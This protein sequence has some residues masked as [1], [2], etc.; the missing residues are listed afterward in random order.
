M[1]KQTILIFVLFIVILL[2]VAFAIMQNVQKQKQIA[3]YNNQYEQYKD[4]Q[5][6]GTDITTQINKA[7]NENEKNNVEKDEKGY[8]KNNNSNSIKIY[9]KLQPE[10]EYF[11]M[12]RI[13]ELGMTEFV[14][15]FNIEYFKCTQINYHSETSLVS[16]VYY[17]V[18]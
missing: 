3:N 10:G 12:E 5:I 9:V 1:K 2:L 11:P 15:N 18:I 16:E 6:Y 4:S 13:F 7:M 14:K 8:Y 17:E